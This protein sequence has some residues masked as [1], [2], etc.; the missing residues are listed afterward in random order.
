MIV[1]YQQHQYLDNGSLQ[2]IYTKWD[3]VNTYFAIRE[4][5]GYPQYSEMCNTLDGGCRRLTYR[6]VSE[7]TGLSTNTLTNYAGQRVNRFDADTL[8]SLCDYLVCDIGDLIF[9]VEE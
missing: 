7:E 3:F 4:N 9:R 2:Y 8:K 1:R 5:F 6:V